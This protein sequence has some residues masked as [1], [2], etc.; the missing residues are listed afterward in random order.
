MY[1]PKILKPKKSHKGKNFR[2]IV[3]VNSLS[4]GNTKLISLETGILSSNHFKVIKFTIKKFMKKKGSVLVIKYP[5]VPVTK[6]P[7]EVRMGKGK[8]AIN[9]WTCRIG[10]GCLLCKI[11][12]FN[13]ILAIKSLLSLQ[14]KLPI[15]TKIVTT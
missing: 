9:F 2:K 10:L 14:N 15:R 4:Y 5:Q 6:K 8:G 12:T 7:L 3:S 11:E 13:T 1:Q